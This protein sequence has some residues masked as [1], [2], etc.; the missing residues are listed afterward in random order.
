MKIPASKTYI[1]QQL[2]SHPDYPSLLSITDTLNDLGIENTALQIEREKIQEMPLPFL[3]HLNNSE[4]VIVENCINPEKQFAKFFDRWGGIVVAAEK[5]DNWQHKQNSEWL[6]REKKQFN[7]VAVL[8]LVLITFIITAGAMAYSWMYAGLILL[9]IA[10]AFVSWMIVNKELGIENKI[11]DQVCGKDANCNSVIH[12][13]QAKLPFGIGWSD[14]GIIYFSFLLLILLISSFTGAGPDVLISVM[15][16]CSMPVTLLSIYYQWRVEKKWCRLFLMTVALLWAQFLVLLPVTLRQAQGDFSGLTINN[17][18]LTSFLLFITTAAWFRVKPILKENKKLEAEYFKGKRFKNNPDVFKALL[19]K[20]KR[21]TTNP[22]GL[23]ILLGDLAAPNKIIKVCNPYCGPCA[24]AH[25]EVEE[26]L[27]NNRNIKVQMLFNA[28][29]DEKDIRA[30]PVKHLLALHDKGDQQLMQQ[31]LDDW[32]MA[33][34][35]DYDAFAAK[36]ILN[37]ELEAQ[38]EKL[39]TMKEWCDEVKIEFTPTFFINGYQLP[40]QYKIEDVKYFL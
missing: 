8:I 40:K 38:G 12:S 4:Y 7:Q 29:D 6:L 21:I 34:K 2:L 25:P 28:A 24:K 36:Y 20:Q 9:T 27:V 23:G 33:D 26:L 32:Y 31:A 30:K 35:K 18:L 39:R 17:A 11:A 19:E 37:G 22:D 1:R 3:A 10:G 16:T 5:P 15:A 14:A 13:K